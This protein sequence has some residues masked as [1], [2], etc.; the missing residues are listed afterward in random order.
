FDP[1]GTFP[2]GDTLSIDDQEFQLLPSDYQFPDASTMAQIYE[3][4]YL[5]VK[6]VSVV[7][8]ILGPTGVNLA[9]S[10]SYDFDVA[11]GNPDGIMAL[12]EALRDQEFSGKGVSYDSLWME[13]SAT[14]RQ[15]FLNLY[16]G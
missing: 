9:P 6:D 5:V 13:D 3:V 10:Y 11:G 14:A 8:S 4:Y 16:G 7:E 12:I 15:D 1:V 2:E